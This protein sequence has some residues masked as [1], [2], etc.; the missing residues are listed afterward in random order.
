MG[1]PLE[2]A[3]ILAGGIKATAPTP[4]SYALNMIHRQGAWEVRKGFG[5]LAQYDTSMSTN[6]AGATAEWGYARHVGSYLMETAFGHTQIV[7]V[8]ESTN[9]AANVSEI[10]T[11]AAGK[12]G[13]WQV[14]IYC[15]SIHDVTTGERWEEP[16]YRHTSEGNP[17]VMQLYKRM[18]QDTTSRDRDAQAWIAHTDSPVW[19]AEFDDRLLF[20]NNAMGIMMYSPSTFSGNRRKAV[21]LSSGNEFA[22]G[23]CESAVVVRVAPSRG[24]AWISGAGLEYL[25][26][27]M[28]GHPVAAVSYGDRV[29]YASGRML[30]FSDPF[31]PT[32]LLVG[33]SFDVPSNTEITALSVIGDQLIIFTSDQVWGFRAPPDT[34]V[35]QGRGASLIMD[36]VGCLGPNAVTSLGSAIVWC[37]TSG[38]Y[39]IDGSGAPQKISADIEPFFTGFITDPATSWYPLQGAVGTDAPAQRNLTLSLKPEL[40]SLAYSEKL[41]ALFLSVPDENL[42]L[43]FADSQWSVWSFDSN[44]YQGVGLDV[45]AVQNIQNPWLL[46]R[47]DN[48]FAIGG[49]DANAFVD[50]SKRLTA[51]PSTYQDINDDTTARSYYILRYGLGGA[52]DRSVDDE[53][54]RGIAGKYRLTIATAGIAAGS[55]SDLTAR[56]YYDGWVKI[57]PWIKVAEGY[58]FT[59]GHT[60]NNRTYLL[61]VSIVPPRSWSPTALTNLIAFDFKFDNAHWVPVFESVG[62]SRVLL[63]LPSERLASVTGYQQSSSV[64]E[65]RVY[66]LGTGNLNAAGPV[67]H[68]RWDGATAAG[69]WYHK[70]GMNLNAQR[71]NIILYIPMTGKTDAAEL[72]GMTIEPLVAATPATL[73]YTASS[74]IGALS[75]AVW[76]QWA[77]SSPN[78]EDNVAQ[79]VDWA[80]KSDEI[81]SD[82]PTR[83]S[84]RGI[85]AKVLSHGLGVDVV[86]AHPQRLFNTLVAAD[87]KM[88]MAQPVDHAGQYSW[89]GS[90]PT[91]RPLSIQTNVYPSSSSTAINTLRGRLINPSNTLNDVTFNH[92]DAGVGT[93]GTI[94]STDVTKGDVLVADEQVDTIVTS[95]GVKCTSF[96]YLLFGFM[97]NRAEALKIEMAKGMYRPRGGGRRRRGR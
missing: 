6:P 61:P 4:G 3:D 36:G 91:R 83:V 87:Q 96:S 64:S 12:Q 13:N 23:H 54:Y 84:A 90:D 78:R 46:A 65:V 69:S 20:G 82:T 45:G 47:G 57:L 37:D 72:S 17:T 75:S 89:A 92:P 21:D 71:E 28:V 52:I 51:H 55:S 27:S 53:D 26:E 19:F 85:A 62:N 60:A 30:Y 18:G 31:Y 2:E 95:D 41:D 80:Y 73:T 67:M 56:S 58:R 34:L 48:L 5:Q 50:E 93:W 66:E 24:L 40:V 77:I 79:P 42:T 70:P 76:E 59:G 74:L 7:S 63:V 1:V 8:L 9:M 35:T 25:T 10:G 15:V 97:Q 44:T 39:I 22:S 94:N 38:V 16:I 86:N 68:V 32:S 11:T 81:G 14:S 43:C 49:I 29:V 88:N 33:N